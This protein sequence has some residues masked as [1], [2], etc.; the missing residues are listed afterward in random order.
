VEAHV[1]HLARKV[2]RFQRDS[3]SMAGFCQNSDAVKLLGFIPLI[4]KIADTIA[5]SVGLLS[6]ESMVEFS[7]C[8]SCIACC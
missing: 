2:S 6:L 1:E 3:G 8:I 5:G 4:L 7:R